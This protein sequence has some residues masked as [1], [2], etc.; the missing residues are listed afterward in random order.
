MSHKVTGGGL[1]GWTPLHIL[2]NGCDKCMKLRDV[3]ERLLDSGYVDLTMFDAMV[4]NEV[5]VFVS[6]SAMVHH[7]HWVGLHSPLAM[8]HQA[9]YVCR[10]RL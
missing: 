6:L 8:P 10:Q 1:H 5:I 4:N 7:G 2:C 3:I 9:T